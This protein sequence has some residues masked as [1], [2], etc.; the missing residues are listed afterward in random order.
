MLRLRAFFDARE[1]TMTRLIRIS[2]TSCLLLLPTASQAG[3]VISFQDPSPPVPTNITGSVDFSI[4]ATITSIGGDD[5]AGFVVSYVIDPSSGLQFRTDGPIDAYGNPDYLRDPNYVFY[6][7]SLES[8]SLDFVFQSPGVTILPTTY[9][10]LDFT[11]DGFAVHINDGESKLLTTLPLVATMPGPYTISIDP[12]ISYY[13][14]ANFYQF[15]FIISGSGSGG[16][17]TPVPEPSSML[18]WGLGALAIVATRRRGRT[19]T[20]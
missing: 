4:D 12:A 19:A 17:S 9:T 1:T 8:N 16:Q 11:T 10:L 20:A 5:I 13:V 6:G 2:I 15:N 14:D 18:V 7:S 3:L